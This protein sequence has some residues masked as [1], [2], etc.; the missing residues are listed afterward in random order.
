[1]TPEQAQSII[2]YVA[3]HAYRESFFLA[4]DPP[5]LMSNPHGLIDLVREIGGVTEADAGAWVAEA[6][7][8]RD[9]KPSED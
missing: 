8:E 3:R 5:W 1:M 2:Q 4:P 9:N 7:A 6:V